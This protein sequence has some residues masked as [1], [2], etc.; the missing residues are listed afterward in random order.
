MQHTTQY[1]EYFLTFMILSLAAGKIVGLGNPS[2]PLTP[3]DFKLV[4]AWRQMSVHSRD[5]FCPKMG[6][7]YHEWAQEIET[8]LSIQSRHEISDI[9]LQTYTADQITGAMRARVDYLDELINQN[10]KASLATVDSTYVGVFVRKSRNRKEG[11]TTREELCRTLKTHKR[12]VLVG[13]DLKDPDPIISLPNWGR[14][15]SMSW[16]EFNSANDL[17]VPLSQFLVLGALFKQG[18]RLLVGKWSGWL[19]AGLCLGFRVKVIGELSGASRA[20]EFLNHF[21]CVDYFE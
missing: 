6:S 7:R 18:V 14:F 17:E 10:W 19:I 20:R 5:V 2:A 12:I 3:Q 8:P 16:K 11:N 15:V 4:K 21:R 9:M 13:D 1:G